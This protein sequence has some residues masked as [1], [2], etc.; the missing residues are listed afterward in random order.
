MGAGRLSDDTWRSLVEKAGGRDNLYRV[1]GLSMAPTLR[2]GDV[3]GIEPLAERLPHPG[4]I[5]VIRDPQEPERTLIKRTRSRG[6]DTF[7]VGSDDPS[8]ARDSR[9]FGSLRR[10]DLVGRATWVWSEAEGLRAL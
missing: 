6:D 4:E 3:V 2:P 9:H 10:D 7:A 1:T 5:V 8:E